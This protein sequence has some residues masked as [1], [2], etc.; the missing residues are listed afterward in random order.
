MTNLVAS[1][2]NGWS[3]KS[4]SPRSVDSRLDIA[5]TPHS[6][7]P[8]SVLVSP[9]GQYAVE[10]GE[11]F[12]ISLTLHN[13][14]LR[15]AIV[16]VY[17]DESSAA[18][19]KWCSNPYERLALEANYSSEVRFKI[20]IPV[21]T[22]PGTYDYLI[23]VDAPDHYPEDTPLRYPARVQVLPPVRSDINLNDAT[24]VTRPE[25]S[26]AQPV[27]LPPETPVSVQI[28]VHNRSNHVDQ[29]RLAVEDLPKEWYKLCYPEGLEALGLVLNTDHLALNPGARGVIQMMVNCPKTVLAGRYFATLQLHSIND[30]TL[31][32][33]DVLYFEVQPTYKLALK[34]ETIVR[35]IKRQP[36]LV[37]L[38]ITNAGNTARHITLQAQE[39]QEKPLFNYTIEPQTLS[40]PSMSTVQVELRAMP[41]RPRRRAW[42]G[43]G[44]EIDTRLVM[45]DQHNL[46]LPEAATVALLWERRPW[47]HIL[48][49]VLAGVGM[50]GAIALLLWWFFGR[51]LAPPKVMRFEAT[52]STYYQ[53]NNDF[54]RL[55]WQIEHP[56]QIQ[57]IELRGQADGA[58]SPRPIR[59]DFS[60]GI[61]A[62]LADHCV[63]KQQLACSNVF[64]GARQPG[65]Y[66]FTLN[67]LSKG[68]Q[69]SITAETGAIA[70][71]PTPPAEISHFASIQQRY[72]EALAPDSDGKT[73]VNSL[74]SDNTVALDWQITGVDQLSHLTLVGRLDDGS[75]LDKPQHYDLT[76]G[77]PQ[78]LEPFC[79]LNKTA[80]VC[81]AV[82]TTAH[83]V[84]QYVF[85]LNAF[86]PD[87]STP[88]ATQKTEAIAIVPA[89]VQIE[90]FTIDGISPTKHVV[91][92]P[93]PDSNASEG[94]RNAGRDTVRL[95]WQVK[96]GP[97][98]Q[99]E[100]LPSPGSVPLAGTLDYPLTANTQEVLTLRVTSVTGRQVTR[101]ITLEALAITPLP[102]S[103]LPN[104]APVIAPPP[105]ALPAEASTNSTAPVVIEESASSA[106][107][108]TPNPVAE[109]SIP[110]PLA[111][112]TD[113]IASPL[114]SENK[115]MSQS[116]EKPESLP[117]AEPLK[118]TPVIGR[119]S[120]DSPLR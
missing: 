111:P 77:L 104:S 59:Y 5:T 109:V 7:G 73:D 55:T 94:E 105:I 68:G 96:G 112:E 22:L 110:E 14:G 24:F 37:Y 65:R 20:T 71:Q 63:L 106:S 49:V 78:V 2:V 119:R 18:F 21:Q 44:H 58:T 30:P 43:R 88:I 34:S 16:D 117:K 25:S 69:R 17:V 48:L 15:G 115:P 98:T 108:T 26:S 81:R 67:I 61:P 45:E 36:A 97:F 113:P 57:A 6:M 80:L 4:L 51:A 90:S 103:P 79:R 9:S 27:V 1:S 52:A 91:D 8:L 95:D 42:F 64:T 54:V 72:W 76:D 87:S 99:V 28:I 53:Q 56:K 12:D 33:M 23:V 41:D 66:Q 13:Q 11:S 101:S 83:T 75:V 40:I 3:Q 10:A 70:I 82:P 89:P 46:P 92:L 100:L 118:W 102:L 19:C 114:P 60:D 47:W 31:V 32:L 35:K 38:H 74:D 86:G 85:E 120:P 93:A 116:P 50:V 29:F 62:E 39:D 107:P 84:G